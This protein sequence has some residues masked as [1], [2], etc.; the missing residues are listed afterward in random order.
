MDKT[1]LMIAAPKSGSGKTLIVCALLQ[2]CKDRG[3][4]VR[5]FKCGPDYIDPMFHRKVIGVPSRNLD[6]FFSGE[7][8]IRELFRMDR[9]LEEFSV[10]EGVMGLYDGLGGIRK[11]GSSYHLAQTLDIPIVLVMDAHGM[12]RTLIPVLAGLLSYDTDKRIIGIILNRVSRNTYD[13]LA[14]LVKEELSVPLLGYFPENKEFAIGSRHL[15]LMM[16]EEMERMQQRIRQAAGVLRECTGMERLLP[17][18]NR[19]ISGKKMQ[20]ERGGQ[21]TE[22]RKAVCTGQKANEREPVRIAVALD[23]AFNFYYEDNLRLLREAGAQLTEF[24]PLKDRKLPDGTDGILLG[25]GYPE[26]FAARLAANESMREAVR[27]AIMQGMPSVAECGGFMYLHE[28]LVTE[29]GKR[30]PMAGVIP[31]VCSYQ[32][33]LVRFGYV[34]ITE[35]LPGFF[36][37]DRKSRIKGHEFHYFDSTQNGDGCTAQKPVSGKSWECIWT[38][39]NR[40]W[41]FPHLYYPSNPQFAVSFVRSCREYRRK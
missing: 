31:G 24:S 17:P 8:E 32:G 9:S 30:Y 41:G 10:V 18:D 25:G 22:E 26:L 3:I 28:Q 34:E 33:K 2:L 4:P 37:T 35:K 21:E 15:G 13:A 7:Q 14:E 11:E 16:P 23:D 36:R 29:D 39:R 20:K 19:I 1:G 38:G 12:G 6:T 27:N 40:W 5:A